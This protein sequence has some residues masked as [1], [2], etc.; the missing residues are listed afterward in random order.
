M[1]ITPPHFP[2]FD[3][4]MSTNRNLDETYDTVFQTTTGF[5]LILRIYLSTDVNLA[6]T[7][8]LHGVRATHAWLDIRMKVIGYSHIASDKSWRT[9]NIKLGD[10]V[11]AVI[12]H[13]QVNPP[14]IL[15]ITDANLRRLQE[16]LTTGSSSTKLSGSTNNN[17]GVGSNQYTSS[18]SSGVQRVD[19]EY[20]NNGHSRSNN[21]LPTV[22]NDRIKS[23]FEVDDDEVNGLIPPTPE[24]F[25]ELDAMPS[26]EIKRIVDNRAF[27]DLFVEGTSEVSTLRE[28]KQS[29]EASNVDAARAN[30]AHEANID[31]LTSEVDTLKEDLNMKVQRYQELDSQRLAL[32]QPPSTQDVI[33]KLTATK[34]D[35]YRESEEYAEQWIEE[36]GDGE[37]V[38]EFIKKFIGVRQLYH[39]RA[40]KVERLEIEPPNYP[41]G[42][43]Y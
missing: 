36:S 9:S 2:R 13:F 41:N 37:D 27:L 8:T 30:L 7:M 28:L 34:R 23:K 14:S 5:A 31:I 12:Q 19:N 10:A 33:A 39:I 15:E 1:K 25:L 4:N 43:R 22:E 11:Y 26:S 29:I 21:Q 18:A 17:H 24:S 16:S 20:S 3:I 6:P 42:D 35:A 40:A 38:S 32:T